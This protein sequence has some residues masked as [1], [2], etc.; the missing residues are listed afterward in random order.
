VP[1]DDFRNGTKKAILADQLD[2]AH[3]AA[4]KHLEKMLRVLI[5]SG[6]EANAIKIK[7][8]LLTVQVTY[9]RARNK[10]R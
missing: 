9:N 6:D 1:R 7:Q 4:V 10:L 5:E 3:H 2:N 8:A